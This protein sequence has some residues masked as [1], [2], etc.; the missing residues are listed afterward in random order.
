[1]LLVCARAHNKLTLH[2]ITEV[3]AGLLQNSK[4]EDFDKFRFI[5]DIHLDSFTGRYLIFSKRKISFSPYPS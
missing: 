4:K 5:L 1:M 2:T 3:R